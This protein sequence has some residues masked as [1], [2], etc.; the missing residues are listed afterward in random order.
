M[1]VEKGATKVYAD[2]IRRCGFAVVGGFRILMY[3]PDK[4]E[5]FESLTDTTIQFGVIRE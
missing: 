2:Q 5:I 1:I 3:D 4:D